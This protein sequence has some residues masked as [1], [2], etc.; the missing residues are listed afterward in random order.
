MEKQT[1]RTPG[2]AV[3]VAMERLGWTQPDLAYV[4]GTTTA[5]VNQILNDKRA[6]SHNMAKALAAALDIAPEELARLQAEWDIRKADDPDPAIAT[7]AKIF[8]R[9]PLREMAKRG[10][11]DPEHPSKSIETQIC[12]FFGVQS[13]NEVPYLAH[14]AKRTRYDHIP[15]PQLAWLFRVRQIAKE[16]HTPVFDRALLQHAISQFSDFRIEPEAVRYIPKLLNAAGVRLVIV[17][18]LPNS[19]ID[20]VC[21]W[22]DANSPVIGL[23]IRYDR[24][25]NFW[26]VLR[27]ECSHVMHG[28]GKETAIIDF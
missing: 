3:K 28:H 26:F 25:D 16:M 14:S 22:L 18:A 15:A 1:S 10:W 4:L 6:I 9:Y 23:S 19:R 21:F 13:L 12:E 20:G 5:A 27:H 24:I 17:E 2:D 7:R 8:A 11:V